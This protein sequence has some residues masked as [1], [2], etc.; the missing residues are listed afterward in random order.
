MTT[1]SIATAAKTAV[2]DTGGEP[3]TVIVRRRVKTGCETT[4]EA[5][6]QA[7]IR[8]AL[9]FPGNRGIHVLRPDDESREYTVVDRFA[10]A[11]AR[12]AFKGSEQY[13]AWMGRLRELTEHDPY[14]E[15]RGGLAGWFTVP[16]AARPPHATRIKMA[17]VTFVGVYPLTSILPP[18]FRWLLPAWHPLLVNV[19]VTALI[20]AGLAWVVMPVLTRLLA[21]WL[22]PEAI[23][24]TAS[25]T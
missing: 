12:E 10:N 9:A 1:A 25:T 15:E 18:L 8:F 4:F 17:L 14:I 7:F 24:G 13:H 2:S 20:V 22:F 6:M 21:S 5:E 23:H 11:A 19:V 3:V 16:G